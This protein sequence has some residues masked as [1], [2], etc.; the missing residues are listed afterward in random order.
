ML[1]VGGQE[2]RIMPL[3]A[4]ESVI[5]LVNVTMRFAAITAME[6][7]VGTRPDAGHPYALAC[8]SSLER[9]A[10]SFVGLQWKQTQIGRNHGGLGG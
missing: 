6:A 1:G 9:L 7:S 3:T 2:N 8:D 5:T 4:K 10:T